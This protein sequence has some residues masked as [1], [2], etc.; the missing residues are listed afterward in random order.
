MAWTQ[1]HAVYW[2]KDIDPQGF[3]KWGKWQG[4]V[5]TW[6]KFDA[7]FN[8]NTNKMVI[9]VNGKTVIAVDD[10]KKSNVTKGL[11]VGQ[12]GFAANISGRYDHM[13][14]GFDDIYISESQARVELSNSSEWK[15]GIVSE[16]V[17]PRSWNDNEISFEYK[18]DYLSDSQPIYLYVIN[19]NGQ[20]NQKGFPLLSKAPEKIAVFKVE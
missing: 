1:M 10:F 20:V 7:W 2:R 8:S 14:F 3:V 16:I 12:I 19:E 17:S 18:T 13:V 15:E 6:N 4:E 11:T 5:G 9:K